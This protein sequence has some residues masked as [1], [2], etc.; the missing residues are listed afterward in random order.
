[1]EKLKF[2]FKIMLC[3]V[4]TAYFAGGYAMAKVNKLDDHELRI[5]KLEPDHDVLTRTSQRVEDIAKFLGVP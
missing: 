5:Q 3:M 2:W 4:S 1:M